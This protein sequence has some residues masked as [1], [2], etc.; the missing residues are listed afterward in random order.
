MAAARVLQAH[1]VKTVPVD[2][3]GS[4]AIRARAP[5]MSYAWK[6]RDTLVVLARLVCQEI[7]F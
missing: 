2:L 4:V 3:Q 6:R 1:L 7:I 5:K